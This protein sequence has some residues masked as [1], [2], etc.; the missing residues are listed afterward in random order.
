[1]E[2]TR[3]E[4]YWGCHFLFQGLFLTQ[5]LNMCLL[6]CRWILYHGSHLGSPIF[7]ASPKILKF[8]LSVG[9]R[10]QGFGITR[11]V[12]HLKFTGTE[13]PVF[14]TFLDLDLH[15]SLSGCLFVSFKVLYNKAVILSPLTSWVLCAALGNY[16]K[17]RRKSWEPPIYT[18]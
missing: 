1:M 18:Q 16:W 14:G 4:Y 9:Q 2:F 8:T 12:V 6:H 5:G 17:P 13:D 11:R 3:Q 15:I 10:G 7:S